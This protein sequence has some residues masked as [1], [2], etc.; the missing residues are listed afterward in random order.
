MFTNKNESMVKNDFSPA[1][2]MI[3]SGTII[4]GDIQ[5]KGDIRVDGILKGSINTE[6]KVVLG[7]N[8][9]IEGD[10]VCQDADISGTIN[11]KI[12]VS[13]LLSLKATARLNGDIV[14]SKLSIEPGA[15]FTGSCS[16][17][18][19]IKD[20]KNVEKPEKKERSA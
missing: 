20:I 8:G 3:G 12:T 18:A 19:V 1:I 11:A 6:G 16:M 17:G 15:T 2:N 10:V 4:T 13:K 7:A 14:T 9:T 5:S